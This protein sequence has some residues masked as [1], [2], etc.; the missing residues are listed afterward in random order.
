MSRPK[1]PDYVL[2]F[3]HI[4][5][6]MVKTMT[7]RATNTSWFPVSFSIDRE[8]LPIHLGFLVDMSKVRNL[9]GAPDHETV[10]FTVTFD[11]RAANLGL[12]LIETFVIINV[13]VNSC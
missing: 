3:G 8:T 7:V 6:G 10:E 12:G 11:P 1:L 5:L 13:S 9:P 4:I 2:D